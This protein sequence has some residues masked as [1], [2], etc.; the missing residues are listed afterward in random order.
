MKVLINWNFN[1]LKK[2]VHFLVSILQ[3][4]FPIQYSI[5]AEITQAFYLGEGGRKV[6]F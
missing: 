5:L 6:Y 4:F 3:N 2:N 1:F